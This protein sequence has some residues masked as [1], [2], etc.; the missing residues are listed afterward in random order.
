VNPD[1]KL[2]KGCLKGQRKS[3]KK[4]YENYK[5][6]L[7]MICLRYTSSK[8]EAEDIL[9]DSFLSIF[10][11]LHQYDPDK[12]KLYTWMR[13]VTINT[14]LQALRKKKMEFVELEE[15]FIDYDHRVDFDPEV[16]LKMEDFM[17]IMSALPDGYRTV[18]NLYQIEGYSHKEIA[19]L[20]GISVGTSRS[21]YYKA[22]EKLKE[23]IA[24]EYKLDKS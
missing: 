9:Q 6:S 12:G 14:A 15:K 13:R 23:K 17:Q 21:Q 11:D 7:F 8:A 5:Q 19:Q 16:D 10:K 2:I 3:Q 4:L 18:F 20:L 24:L 22:K 1:S